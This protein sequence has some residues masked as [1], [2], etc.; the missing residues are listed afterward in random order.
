M[1]MYW[2][3]ID[4]TIQPD[5]S[6]I[7]LSIKY[8]MSWK[9]SSNLNLWFITVFVV[10]LK[11]TGAN[12]ISSLSLYFFNKLFTEIWYLKHFISFKRSL[13][14]FLILNLLASNCTIRSFFLNYFN[15][16]RHYTPYKRMI[17]FYYAELLIKTKFS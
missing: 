16:L 9:E 12:S 3:S 15:F 10:E 5:A 6:L 13:N 11:Q 1:L 4:S 14:N 8:K 7:Q 2:Y 17:C